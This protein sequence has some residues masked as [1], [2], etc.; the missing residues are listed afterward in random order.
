MAGFRNSHY[1]HECN[2]YSVLHVFQLLSSIPVHFFLSFAMFLCLKILRGTSKN[3]PESDFSFV[4]MWQHG[5]VW[6]QHLVRFRGYYYLCSDYGAMVWKQVMDNSA[7]SK[8]CKWPLNLVL[9]LWPVWFLFVLLFYFFLKVKNLSL[10]SLHLA[11][12]GHLTTLKIIVL[13]KNNCTGAR[14]IA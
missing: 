12:V 10:L 14:A 6:W 2:T 5:K 3:L 9:S 4:C 1:C 11:C 13:K 7:G 8:Q